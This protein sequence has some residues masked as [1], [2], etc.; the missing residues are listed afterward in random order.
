MSAQKGLSEGAA[1]AAPSTPS[2]LPTI[3][4]IQARTPDVLC[5][6]HP[7]YVDQ[8]IMTEEN[9]DKL[10]VIRFGSHDDMD[11]Q[12]QDEVLQKLV[13]E[14][15]QW[16][17]FYKCD[18]RPRSTNGTR[19]L[20]AV[21]WGVPNFNEMYELYDKN[22]IMFFYRNKHMMCDFGTGNNNK[23][24][25]V[26]DNKR[27]MEMIL[28]VIWQGARKGRGLVNCPKDYSTRHAY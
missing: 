27:E 18:N 22:T 28:T 7:Y 15:R 1:K 19:T 4:Q 26:L 25:W 9:A 13:P 14:V 3:Q 12:R 20:D 16:V 8:A 2:G 11:C 6:D 24:N 10:V 17:V 5:L 21:P 23:I